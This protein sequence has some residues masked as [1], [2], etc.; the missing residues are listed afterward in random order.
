MDKIYTLE[1]LCVN[2]DQQYTCPPY[3]NGSHFTHA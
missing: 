3:N 1:K 2:Y